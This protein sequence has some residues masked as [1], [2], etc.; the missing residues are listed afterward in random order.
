MAGTAQEALIAELLGDVGLLHDQVKALRDILPDAV[1]SLDEQ[2]S[3]AITAI[4]NQIGQL[5]KDAL[6]FRQDASALLTSVKATAAKIAEATAQESGEKEAE[7]L[8]TLAERLSQRIGDAA[9]ESVATA[10]R[11]PATDAI[12]GVTAAMRRVTDASDALS[13]AADQLRGRRW[14]IAAWCS[15]AALLGGLV[16][17]A[18][19]LVAPKGGMVARLDQIQATIYEIQAVR[20]GTTVQ[21]KPPRK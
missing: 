12:S 2:T 4:D 11:A 18:L 20:P 8:Q 19:V 10:V 1:D 7:K 17:G 14:E 3:T 6:A 21:S 13:K 15:G 9:Q 5:R 16:G